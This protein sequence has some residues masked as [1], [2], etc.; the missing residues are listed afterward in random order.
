MIFAGGEAL[1]DEGVYV[2]VSLCCTLKDV[3][4]ELRGIGVNWMEANE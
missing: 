3:L 1:N 4:G 2:P